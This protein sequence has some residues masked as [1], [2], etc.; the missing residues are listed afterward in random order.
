ML[1]D[2]PVSYVLPRVSGRARLRLSSGEEQWGTVYLMPA[3]ERHSGA[4]TPLEM[5]NRFERFFPF[6]PDGG[7]G[8]LLVAKAQTLWLAEDGDETGGD[9]VQLVGRTSVGLDVTLV[10]GTMLSGVTA[11][12]LPQAGGRV[13][14]YLNVA[15]E[16][17]FALAA[18]ADTYF[19]N[20]DHVRYARPHDEP[21]E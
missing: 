13:L 6:R 16:R 8:V 20:R 1:E 7:S 12:D 21:Q 4:E 17:F 18:A 3:A 9:A 11:F 14:D 10:D 2:L 15:Q 5:L 19:V